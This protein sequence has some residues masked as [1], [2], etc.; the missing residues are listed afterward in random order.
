MLTRENYYEKQ[1]CSFYPQELRDAQPSPLLQ[2]P[3][4]V[5]SKSL[6]L[7]SDISAVSLPPSKVSNYLSADAALRPQDAPIQLITSRTFPNGYSFAGDSGKLIK[8]CYEFHQYENKV[9]ARFPN[10]Y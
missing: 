10:S 8:L 7:R 9:K 3:E 5:L 4:P 2:E 1:L 6:S